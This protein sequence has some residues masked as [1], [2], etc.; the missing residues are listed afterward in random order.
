MEIGAKFSLILQS[1]IDY[2]VYGFEVLLVKNDD[3]ENAEKLLFSSGR[4]EKENI[5][6]AS[7]SYKLVRNES[8]LEQSQEEPGTAAKRNTVM[9]AK[10]TSRKFSV[11]LEKKILFL[12]KKTTKGYPSKCIFL[13]WKKMICINQWETEQ[14]D[15]IR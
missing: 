11:D 10:A 1:D 6:P 2:E 7:Y 9:Y 15:A 14:T 3:E 13:T 4:I 5:I 8:K 12:F